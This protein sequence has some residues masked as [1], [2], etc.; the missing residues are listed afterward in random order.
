MTSLSGSGTG[1]SNSLNIINEMDYNSINKYEIIDKQERNLS[2]SQN[3]NLKNIIN[4]NSNIYST[5]KIESNS[6]KYSSAGIVIDQQSNNKTNNSINEI[7]IKKTN[8]QINDSYLNNDSLEQIEKF[9]EYKNKISINT[10]SSNSTSNK[11]IINNNIDIDKVSENSDFS[12]NENNSICTDI[13]SEYREGAQKDFSFKLQEEKFDSIMTLLKNIFDYIFRIRIENKE[14]FLKDEY[15]NQV[16]K[17]VNQNSMININD[18]TK[19]WDH[20]LLKEDKEGQNKYFI[21][22]VMKSVLNKK[23]NIQINEQIEKI[24]SDLIFYIYLFKYRDIR[25]IAGYIEEVNNI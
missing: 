8:N 18:V 16:K 5:D 6:G 7:N 22:T 2:D 25:F 19:D 12:A 20:D 17:I 9:S 24:L 10:C 15:L 11:F 23:Y 4:T 3:D 14:I 13:N 21:L 1:N